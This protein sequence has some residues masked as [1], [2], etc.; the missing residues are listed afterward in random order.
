[1]QC[2]KIANFPA[3]KS[4]SKPFSKKHLKM[5][6]SFDYFYSIF[7]N[8]FLSSKENNDLNLRFY[9]DLNSYENQNTV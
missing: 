6:N 8:D 1:M 7:Y 3:N 4:L 5:D 2:I 9:D